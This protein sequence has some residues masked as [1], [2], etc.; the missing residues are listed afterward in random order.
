L[1]DWKQIK[2]LYNNTSRNERDQKEKEEEK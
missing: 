1:T 2:Y